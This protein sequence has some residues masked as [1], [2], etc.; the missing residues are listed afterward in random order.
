VIVP[1]NLIKPYQ[2]A[3]QSRD[4]QV[5]VWLITII[6]WACHRRTTLSENRFCG[7][8]IPIYPKLMN[9][10]YECM[11]LAGPVFVLVFLICV[12]LINARYLINARCLI[13]VRYLINAA[14]EYLINAQYF[15]NAACEFDTLSTLRVSSIPYQRLVSYQGPVPY[16]RCVCK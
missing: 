2:I 15:I 6:L 7:Q 8:F 12:C 16:Q 4:I 3:T 13:N 5:C 9:R 10:P 11:H 1:P 14:C